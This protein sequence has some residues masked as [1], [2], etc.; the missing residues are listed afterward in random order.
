MQ[1]NFY[2]C[3]KLKDAVHLAV[4]AHAGQFRKGTKVPYITHPIEVMGIVATITRDVDVLAAAVLHDTVEDTVVTAEDIRREFGNRVAALV[5]AESE[6]KMTGIPAAL[7]WKTRKQA[8]IDH[9]RTCTDIDV[10]IISLGDK[11]SNLRCIE[12]DLAEIGQDL[13]N[14]FNQKDPLMH[15]WYYSSFL[16]TLQELHDTAAYKEYERL[17]NACWKSIASE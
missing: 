5:C 17:V 3:K 7:S 10:K 8:T 14:R 6:D 13:W 11:L 1:D 2:D 4:A 15:K 12:R 16:E 9:L